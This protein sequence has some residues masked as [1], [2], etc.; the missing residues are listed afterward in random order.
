VRFTYDIDHLPNAA[1]NFEV[2]VGSRWPGDLY[3][4]GDD[5]GPVTSNVKKTSFT[6]EELQEP[7][8]LRPGSIGY[9]GTT[10]SE[11]E[12]RRGH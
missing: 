11:S 7:R 4:N 10:F 6:I 2:R 12:L 5:T 1:L 8:P 9:V 3:I